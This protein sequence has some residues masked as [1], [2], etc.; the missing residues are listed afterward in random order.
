MCPNGFSYSRTMDK[1]EK[2]SGLCEHV[3]MFHRPTGKEEKMFY[4]PIN[5][6]AEKSTL[7]SLPAM[8]HL[9]LPSIQFS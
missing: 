8:S 7:M 2:N 1:G 9:G 4:C 6:N 5:V 3:E